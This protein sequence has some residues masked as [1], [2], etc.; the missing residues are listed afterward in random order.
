MFRSH[1]W[2]SALIA[3]TSIAAQQFEWRTPPRLGSG[4]GTALAFDVARSRTVM[5]F[6]GET[7]EWDGATWRQRVTANPMGTRYFPGY[8]HDPGRGVTVL[9]AG[10]SL[11]G[12]PIGDTWEWDGSSWTQVA[13]ATAPSWRSYTAM[14]Y[15][16]VRQ[17]VLM[18]GGNASFPLDDT[19][20][21]DGTNWTQLFPVTSPPVR[22]RHTLA[23][24]ES[25]ATAVMFGGIGSGGGRLDETW[26]WNGSNWA[27]RFPATRPARRMNHA[28]AYDARR[29]VTVLFG[30]IDTPVGYDDTWEWDGT[31]WTRVAIGL[32]APET[33]PTHEMCYDSVRGEM[34]QFEDRNHGSKTWTYDGASWQVAAP[35]IDPGLRGAHR[36]VDDPERGEI[37]MFDSA[38]ASIT[39]TWVHRTGTWMHRDAASQPSARNDAALAFDPASRQVLLFGG[40]LP[41]PGADTWL[42]DGSN[43]LQAAP[44]V[45][46]PA[47]SAAAMAGDSTRGRVVLYGGQGSGGLLDDTW[48]WD[49]TNWQQ[50]SPSLVP[51]RRKNHAMSFDP[52]RN[53]T[54]LF[55]GG[56]YLLPPVLGDHWQWNGSN[57]TAI[58]GVPLPPGRAG[59]GLVFDTATQ[60]TLLV[61]GYYHLT[62]AVPVGR[63]DVWEWNGAQ[64]TARVITA[65]QPWPKRITPVAHDPATHR[66]LLFGG[67][68]GHDTWLLGQTSA[69]G[70][71]DYG[72]GCEG[73]F[74]TPALAAAGLAVSGNDHFEVQ[75]SSL[76]PG[77]LVF[78]VLGFNAANSPLP[79]GCTALV[80]P[81]T[82]VALM[83]NARG[84]ARFA[85]P[86]PPSPSFQGL[87]IYLQ[88]AAVDPGGAYLGLGALTAGLRVTIDR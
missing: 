35:A 83:A 19:W 17:R 57:W 76:R 58:V 70:A 22:E 64:W 81:V 27:Q 61:G 1:A 30:G 67:E 45:S 85:M 13:T 40:A 44:A 88:G 72:A 20:E 23:Y 14:T 59:H 51:P 47:R 37:V 12:G 75:A 3:C 84:M 87:D 82:F 18:F 74:G 48:E 69:A 11:G 25:R 71:V 62:F 78:L 33:G 49:G 79:G 24:D 73:S 80:M 28:M 77:G 43:W 5:V 68:G 10:Q 36:L 4:V 56:D 65:P 38:T 6:G 31:A 41:S 54:V 29:Q 66:T 15:D 50:R 32:A 53:V 26:E 9:F 34:V 46:P 63:N 42:W 39:E 8:A 86:L 60:T 16:T 2:T 7:W 55:G 21:Y 52:Q